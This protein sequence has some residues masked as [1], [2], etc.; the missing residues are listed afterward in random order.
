V[1][2]QAIGRLPHRFRYADVAAECPGVSR[3]TIRRAL[4]AMRDAGV[5]RCLGTGR[6][7]EWEKLT[8]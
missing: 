6:N 8:D 3:P 2:R 5:I 1:V 7:A 4:V